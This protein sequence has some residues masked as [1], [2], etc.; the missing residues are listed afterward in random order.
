M[1]VRDKKDKTSTRVS[2]LDLSPRPSW[3]EYFLDGAEWAGARGD[4]TRRRIG[5]V[6]VD[7]HHRIIATGY[8][9]APPGM[10]GCLEGACPRGKLESSE[11]PHDTPYDDPTSPGYCI[12][13]HAEVNAMLNA[14]GRDLRGS[15]CYVSAVPDHRFVSGKP[16]PRCQKDLAAAGVARVVWRDEAGSMFEDVPKFM[17]PRF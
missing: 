5:A 1:R 12:S 2:D 7:S 11:I 8:N 16:C 14:S 4:C 6:F 15:T 17:L 13:T 10:S 3:D 9:G